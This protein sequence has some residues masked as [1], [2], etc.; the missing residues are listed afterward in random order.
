MTCAWP[1]ALVSS[2]RLRGAGQGCLQDV[3]RRVGGAPAG[4]YHEVERRP[5]QLL[6]RSQSGMTRVTSRRSSVR[7][8]ESLA[9]VDF[10]KKEDFHPG[11]TTVE[12]HQDGMGVC[13]Y[14]AL[15]KRV[16]GDT[17]TLGFLTTWSCRWI[18]SIGSAF[19]GSY[20]GSSQTRSAS[21]PRT[22]GLARQMRSE[23]LVGPS[24][25]WHSTRG[26]STRAQSQRR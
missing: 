23:G 18:H 16:L 11:P 9:L 10:H 8:R 15:L 25:R 13:L 19:A 7:P 21:Q 6:P 17:F 1:S 14:L 26:A 2:L 20:G 22:I 12:G 24:P 4:L 5:L 3:Q